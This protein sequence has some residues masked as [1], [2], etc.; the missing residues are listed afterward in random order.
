MANVADPNVLLDQAM[1]FT[2]SENAPPTWFPPVKQEWGSSFVTGVE[3]VKEYHQL[4]QDL[5]KRGE[6]YAAQTG[7]YLAEADKAVAKYGAAIPS[8]MKKAANQGALWTPM[9][10]EVRALS[11]TVEATTGYAFDVVSKNLK[12]AAKYAPLVAR[13]ADLGFDIYNL[14]KAQGLTSQQIIK[15]V[16]GLLDNTV[17]VVTEVGKAFKLSTELAKDVFAAIPWVGKITSALLK[18][19]EV[20]IN[21]FKGT[22][23]KAVLANVKIADMQAREAVVSVC[24]LKLQQSFLPE[25]SVV[26]QGPSPADYFRPISYWLQRSVDWWIGVGEY[27]GKTPGKDRWSV[28]GDGGLTRVPD[29]PAPP[30]TPMWFYV[31]LCGDVLPPM[32]RPTTCGVETYE[33]GWIGSRNFRTPKDCYTAGVEFFK[34]ELGLK[35]FGIPRAT[36][37]CMWKLIQAI[38]ASVRPASSP[39]NFPNDQGRSFFLTLQQICL[40]ELLSGRINSRFLKYLNSE[41]LQR[42]GFIPG[43]KGYRKADNVGPNEGTY[44]GIQTPGMFGGD[45]QPYFGA[46]TCRD[47]SPDSDEDFSLRIDKKFEKQL[48][49]FAQRCQAPVDNVAFY[50]PSLNGGDGGWVFDMSVMEGLRKEPPKGQ[51]ILDEKVITNLD[52]AVEKDKDRFAEGAIPWVALLAAGGAGIGFWMY[53]RNKARGGKR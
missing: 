17:N 52:Q 34:K 24:K 35:T 2:G 27:A 16:S 47:L 39:E 42:N 5:K 19:I 11:A 28:F 53:A 46:A 32:L 15:S 4:S 20:L 13:G 45:M 26:D 36:R 8:W 48:T 30:M 51:L 3:A 9:I 12:E 10:L 6:E 29:M 37:E 41:M 31:A 21:V 23:P 14:V 18:I 22:D 33:P 25:S 7:A 49:E 43:D 38:L 1:R 44:F 40:N 50:D